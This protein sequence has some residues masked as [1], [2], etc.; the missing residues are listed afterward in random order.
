LLKKFCLLAALFI[1]FAACATVAPPPPSLDIE[2]PTPAFS[3]RLTLDDRIAVEEAWTDLRQGRVDRAERVLLR[4]GPQ[5]PFYHAGLGY[6]AF[7][8]KDY[9]AAEEN[10]DLAIENFPAL[11][12]AHLGLAQVYQITGR[13]EP[14]YKEYL[15]VLKRDAENPRAKKES[16]SLRLQLTEQYVGEAKILAAQG[17]IEKTKE[18]YLRALEYSPR[19][20][21]AHVSLARLYIKGKDYQNALFHLRTASA[22]DPKNLSV[23]QE[24]AEALLEAGQ[25]SRS[26]DTY[27]RLLE[28]DPKNKAA[29]DRAESLKTRLGIVDIPSQYSSIPGLEAATKEDVAALIGVK[30]KDIFVGEPEQPPIIVDI[31]TSWASRFV[32]KIA[33]LG[34]MDVYSNHTFQPRK[35]VT[36]AEMAEILVRLADVLKKNGRKVI[37]QIPVERIKIADVP[38]EHPSFPSIALVISYQIMDLASDKTFRPE[39]NIPGREAI[40]ALDLLFGLVK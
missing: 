27:E 7:I 36:R 9:R 30:F 6:A 32:L 17:N 13:A 12:L 29:A 5:N 34:I 38:P 25:L 22:N 35:A 10:F 4:L 3:A 31:A 1:S 20:Q 19:L 15:E 2:N 37:E 33:A 18:A 16:E 11:P 21:E 24:Y 28:L 23:L 26:L 39:A 40:R 14:A 8:R